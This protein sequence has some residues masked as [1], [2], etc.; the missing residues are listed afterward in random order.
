MWFISSLEISKVYDLVGQLS[1]IQQF[2][3]AVSASFSVGTKTIR[4]TV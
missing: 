3:I 1:Y 2:L 4:N